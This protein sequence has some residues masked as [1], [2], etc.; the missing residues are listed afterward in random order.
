[1][2]RLTIPSVCFYCCIAVLA[3]SA[4]GQQTQQDKHCVAQPQELSYAWKSQV[5]NDIHPPDWN[6]YIVRIDVNMV[7][8][9]V[10]W[11]DGHKYKLWV[12]KIT[13]REVDDFL[14]ALNKTCRLPKEPRDAA[15][16]VPVKWESAE[17]T[18]LQFDT[19]H[20]N[21]IRSLSAYVAD[22]GDRYKSLVN[23][24]EVAYYVDA[25]VI[26]VSYQNTYE[27]FQLMVPNASGSP[28]PMFGWFHDVEKLVE[29][30]F[31]HSVWSLQQ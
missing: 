7:D 23:T 12:A 16:A 24:G 27:E 20:Q 4:E 1:M 14:D 22:I 25:G 28:Q 19:I 11:T 31:H 6:A 29:D 9:V 30:K 5:L 26:R 10:L 3:A 17:L 2:T 21:L 18:A 13:Y 8:K 15:K